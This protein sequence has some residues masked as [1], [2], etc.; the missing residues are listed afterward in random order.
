VQKYPSLACGVMECLLYLIKFWIYLWTL[1][2]ALS[3]NI[4]VL[5]YINSN[6][7]CILAIRLLHF[8]HENKTMV[9]WISNSSY[10]LILG[11]NLPIITQLSMYICFLETN[12]FM[13]TYYPPIIIIPKI[14]L[15]IYNFLNQCGV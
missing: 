2:K 3:T 10:Q 9:A 15:C 1:Q 4:L 13:D 11:K 6:M 7:F 12:P 5:D 14:T 8:W